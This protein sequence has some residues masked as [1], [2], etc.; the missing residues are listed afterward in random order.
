MLTEIHDARQVPG[1]GPRRWFSDDYFDLV[2]WYEGSDVAGFQ[3][4]Y[5]LGHEPRAL[6]WERGKGYA[7][8]GVDDGENP[9]HIK[10]SPIL[11][12]DGALDGVRIVD[13]FWARAATLE[14]HLALFVH[15][16]LLE[17]NL[18]HGGR[19]PPVPGSAA[20]G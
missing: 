17:Y 2:V 5:D 9:G 14:R 8:T 7:H 12:P 11:V 20:R 18:A 1:E 15:G 19:T 16:K 13:E 4:T 10:R 6:T 3:L